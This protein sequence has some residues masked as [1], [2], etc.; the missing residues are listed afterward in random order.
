[1]PSNGLSGV[2][3]R[4]S[5]S[6]RGLRPDYPIT[7]LRNSLGLFHICFIAV[8]SG[9]IRRLLGRFQLLRGMDASRTVVA[10]FFH[11]VVLRQGWDQGCAATD[12]ADV[13]EDDFGATIVKFHRPADFD[14]APGEAA[15][16]ADVLQVVREDDDGERAGHLIFAEIHEVDSSCADFHAHDFAR[17]TFGFADVLAGFADSKAVGGCA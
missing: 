11:V 5:R 7:K 15:D 17:H 10:L 12:L 6:A 1:M 8:G 3:P 16:I 13:V 2:T 9:R 14:D 4:I